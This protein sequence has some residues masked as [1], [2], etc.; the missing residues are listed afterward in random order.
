MSPPSHI[1]SG[2]LHMRLSSSPQSAAGMG[3][4]GHA[5]AKVP[6]DL[7]RWESLKL[8][9]S[10]PRGGHSQVQLLYG[11]MLLVPATVVGRRRLTPTGVIYGAAAWLWPV[12][13]CWA[14]RHEPRRPRRDPPKWPVRAEGEQGGPGEDIVPVPGKRYEDTLA[15]ASPD[16][17]QGGGP[18]TGPPP[19]AFSHLMGD[20][21]RTAAP[22]F[23]P[24]RGSR[25]A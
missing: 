4:C 8:P 9:R 23:P 19:R 2:Q 21:S 22:A 24:G 11:L 12:R 1:T 25:H 3:P 6:A 10:R 20:L 7:G 18:V 17:G 13:P 16:A 14:C 15:A 5:A